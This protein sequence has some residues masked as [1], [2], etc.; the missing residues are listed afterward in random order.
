MLSD[1]MKKQLIIMGTFTVFFYILC[2][3]LL[4]T[5]NFQI[6]TLAPFIESLIGTFMAA[7]AVAIITGTILI[8][9][10]SIQAENQKK[11]EVFKEKM[12]LY[13]SIINQMQEAFIQQTGEDKTIITENEKLGLFFTQLNVVLLSKPKTFRSFSELINNLAEEDGSL[14]DGASKLLLD[15]IIDA[16]NDLDVQEKMTN[17]DKTYFSDAIKIAN[18][19]ADK[20]TKLN[21]SVDGLKVIAECN[22]TSDDKK[23]N[24]KRYQ[25]QKIRIEVD[26]IE[27]GRGEVKPALRVIINENSIEVDKSKTSTYALGKAIIE[28][29][30][31]EK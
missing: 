1:E 27:L 3:G 16:R 13:S 2:F 17:Q 7:A 10:S 28:Y 8:F 26:G 25:N 23:Y 22:I 11:Q 24:L 21:Y 30:L 5:H 14:K 9:Q 18:D 4:K 29:F 19:Q 6:W 15:F 20:V 12:S 31:D